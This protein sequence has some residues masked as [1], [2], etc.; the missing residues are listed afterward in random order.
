VALPAYTRVAN[1]PVSEASY[2]VAAE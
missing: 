2:A 1:E